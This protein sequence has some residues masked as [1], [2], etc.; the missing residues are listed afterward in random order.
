LAPLSRS[1]AAIG[2]LPEKWPS[3]M[4]GLLAGSHFV[5]I[6]S[7]LQNLSEVGKLTLWSGAQE[8]RFELA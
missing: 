8:I 1:S 6:T 3:L 7:N 4:S 2:L 5:T